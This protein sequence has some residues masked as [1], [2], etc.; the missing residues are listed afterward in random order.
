MDSTLTISK[1]S[2]MSTSKLALKHQTFLIAPSDNC[3]GEV[4]P[5]NVV[6]KTT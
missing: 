2:C 6:I 5:G 3:S 1:L 4:E